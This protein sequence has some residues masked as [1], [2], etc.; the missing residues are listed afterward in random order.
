MYMTQE[1]RKIW[2]QAKM[3]YDYNFASNKQ[4]CMKN[5]CFLRR[6]EKICKDYIK[7]N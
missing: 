2:K 7:K 6:K 1:A 4:I 3:N 5:E